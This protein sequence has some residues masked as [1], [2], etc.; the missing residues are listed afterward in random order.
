MRFAKVIIVVILLFSLG[1]NFILYT[2]YRNRRAVIS[3]NGQGISKKDVDDFLENQAGPQVKKILVERALVEQEARKQ[4]VMPTDQEVEEAFNEKRDVDLGFAQR[5]NGFPWMAAEAKND[6]RTQLA[7]VRLMTKDVPVSN[8][9]IKAEYDLHHASYDTPSKAVTELAGISD[10]SH[11]EDVKT[12]LEKQISPTAIMEQ[13]KGRVLF[14]G[15]DN[16]FTIRQPYGDTKT[17]AAI[18]TMKPNE[19]KVLPPTP[20]FQRIGVKA[21]VVRLIQI[22]PGKK[23]DLNDPKTKEKIRMNVAGR[24]AKPLQELLSSLWANAK[25]DYEDQNDRRNIERIMFPDRARAAEAGK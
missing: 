6:I 13:F 22:E 3:I 8:D 5:V 23:A 18:F 20:S 9:D 21:L 12:L 2:K 14:F 24:R 7:E 1:L 4:N 15:T 10:P 19:V 11:V 16:K 17:N 25:M